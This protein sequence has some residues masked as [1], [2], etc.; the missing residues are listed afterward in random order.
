MGRHGAGAVIRSS[1]LIIKLEGGGEKEREHKHEPGPDMDFHGPLKHQSLS[2]VTHI[3][4][5]A[6]PHS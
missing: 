3:F 5:T 2:P 4:N 1:G 6:R